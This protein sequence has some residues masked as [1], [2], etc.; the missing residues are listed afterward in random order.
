MKNYKNYNVG[1][2]VLIIFSHRND[3]NLEGIIREVRPSF[4]KIETSVGINNH[5]YGQ[6][7]KI[8]NAS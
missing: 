5:T 3:L 7:K 8:E 6:F 2:K 1:D 4:C